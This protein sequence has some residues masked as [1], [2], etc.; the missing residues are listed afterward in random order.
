MGPT[1]VSS[2]KTPL[3]QSG[4]GSAARGLLTASRNRPALAPSDWRS[5]SKSPE[6]ILLEHVSG[7]VD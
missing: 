1:A 4:A 5:P 7:A 2:Q 6:I 3:D